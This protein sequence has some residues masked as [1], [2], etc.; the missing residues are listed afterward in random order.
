MRA[1]VTIPDDDDLGRKELRGPPP[2]FSPFALLAA[3]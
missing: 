3:A 2:T 1:S